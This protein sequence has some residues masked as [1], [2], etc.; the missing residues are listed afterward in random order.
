MQ[1]LIYRLLLSF[2]IFFLLLVAAEILIRKFKPQ[3]TFSQAM[4]YTVDCYESDPDMQFTLAK[5]HK[6]RMANIN[7]EFNTSA[8][9]NSMGFRGKEVEINKPPGKTRILIIGD[10]MTFGWGLPDDQTYPYLLENILKE[11]GAGNVEV[12]NGGYTGGLSPDSYYI[13]LKEKGFRLKPDILILGFFVGNDITDLDGDIWEKKDSL[14]LPEK[15]SFCCYTVDGH[16]LRNKIISFKYRFPILR[17]SHLFILTADF[18]QKKFNFFLEKS[19]L[20]HR[21]ETYMFCPL[22]SDCIHLFAP[23]EEKTYKIINEIKNMADANGVKFLVALLP[24]DIQLYPNA[25]D[26]YSRY[27]IRWFPKPGEETFLQKRME[28]NFNKSGV[29]YLDLFD[30]FNA[31]RD[32]GYP[33]F[34]VDAH[35]NSIGAALTAESIGQYLL[36][37]KWV[38]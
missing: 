26:K 36:D 1:K 6:C 22:N 38:K 37:N 32:R 3:V 23:E 5:N 17:E 16:I 33:F 20:A 19:A 11:K 31:H 2:I 34:P 30:Y 18:L 28:E 35:F 24:V 21:G 27:N 10:S 13:Y 12:I 8:V 15:I 25:R 29:N 14:G 4:A 7:N 9:I